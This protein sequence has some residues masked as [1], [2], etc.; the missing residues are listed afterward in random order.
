MEEW[1]D[2]FESNIPIFQRSNIPLTEGEDR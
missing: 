1:K 2:E